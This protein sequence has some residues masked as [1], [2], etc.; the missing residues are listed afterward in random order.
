MHFINI[1]IIKYYVSHFLVHLDM[2]QNLLFDDYKSG[3]RPIIVT[4]FHNDTTKLDLDRVF[5]DLGL[6]VMRLVLV[7]GKNKAIVHFQEKSRYQILEVLHRKPV[8][9]GEFFR[10]TVTKDFYDRP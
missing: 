6:E 3:Q 1:T 8:Y 4:G 10:S 5:V 9:I 7:P 2:D